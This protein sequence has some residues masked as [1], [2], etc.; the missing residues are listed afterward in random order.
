MRICVWRYVSDSGCVSVSSCSLLTIQI[1]MEEKGSWEGP[2]SLLRLPTVTLCSQHFSPWRDSN[3]KG[4][5]LCHSASPNPWSDESSAPLANLSHSTTF[6]SPSI[7][8]CNLLGHRNH[9]CFLPVPLSCSVSQPPSILLCSLSLSLSLFT[10]CTLLLLYILIQADILR[11]HVQM[12]KL[13]CIWK[14]TLFSFF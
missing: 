9:F 7:R 2:D 1:E 4:L 14:H 5:A 3:C 12:E 11:L 6:S 13:C 10:T 8:M